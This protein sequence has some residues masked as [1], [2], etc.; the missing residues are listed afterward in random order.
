MKRVVIKL[1]AL[2]A[3]TLSAHV[4]EVRADEV[5][6]TSGNAYVNISPG[7]ATRLIVVN[8]TAPGLSFSGSRSVGDTRGGLITQGSIGT[9]DPGGFIFES[10][11]GSL[12]YNGVAYN[13]FSTTFFTTDTTWTGTIYVFNTE[14]PTAEGNNLIFSFNFVGFGTRELSGNSLTDGTMRFTV[15]TPAS[16]PEP[17][18]LLLLGTGLAGATAAIRKRRSERGGSRPV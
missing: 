5:V 17:M 3:V 10:N 9:A 16:V 1:A 8:W 18:S 2:L 7:D 15:T 13:Y 14:F 6:L 12:T 4:N 11:T